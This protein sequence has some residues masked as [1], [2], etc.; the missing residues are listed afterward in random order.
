MEYNRGV[1]YSLIAMVIAGCVIWSFMSA[2]RS[3]AAMDYP[4]EEIL[5]DA[6][7]LDKHKDNAEVVIVDVRTDKH[8]DGRV[9]PGAIRLPWSEFRRGDKATDIAGRFVGVHSAQNILGKH[10]IAPTDRLVLYDSV[11]RDGGATA[12]YVFWILDLLGHKEKMILDRGIDGWTDAGK[13]VVNRPLTR[14]PLVYTASSDDIDRR[15]LIGGE[16]IYRRLGDPYY[17]IVDV[18][19]QAEYRGRK[20]TKGLRGEPLKMGHIPTAVNINYESAWRD[21]WSKAVKS[22]PALR[23][24]YRG[25]DPNRGVIVYCNSGRRSSFSYFVLRLMGFADVYTYENSWKEWGRP[26]SYFPVEIQE[27]RLSKRTLPGVGKKTA[28]NVVSDGRNTDEKAPRPDKT[29]KGGYVSCG[30]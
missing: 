1:R 23:E 29:P 8:F 12:S 4:R 21:D 26:Q 18:R 20:G 3:T 25:L 27:N 10:G 28:S 6:D 9:V 17:Q 15:R 30:G 22:Y 5:V 2:D 19:S 7:W 11:A 16:F 14:A 13:S 24:L